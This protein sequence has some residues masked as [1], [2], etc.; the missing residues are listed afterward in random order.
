M[1]TKITHVIILYFIIIVS[2]NCVSYDN[3]PFPKP[4]RSAGLVCLSF[5]RLEHFRLLGVGLFSSLCFSFKIMFIPTN[6]LIDV[7]FF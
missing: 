7:E 1:V 6:Q 3:L 4:S 2:L 5:E